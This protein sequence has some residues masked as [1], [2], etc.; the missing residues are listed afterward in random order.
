MSIGEQERRFLEPEVKRI[1]QKQ[2][3]FIRENFPTASWK[4]LVRSICEAYDRIIQ[5]CFS[6]FGAGFTDQ[7]CLIALGSYG[8]KE[9]CP[10]SD[11]DLLILHNGLSRH[12]LEKFSSQLLSLL[13][14]QK[15]PV[16]HSIHTPEQ[17]LELAERNHTALT[18][19]LDARYLAGNQ[20]LFQDLI[21]KFDRI[22]KVQAQN[23]FQDKLKEQKERR[24][25]YGEVLWV[26][27]FHLLEGAGGLRDWHL[28]R[29]LSK[30]LERKSPLEILSSENLL[31]QQEKK[32]VSKA[33]E[34][35]FKTRIALHLLTGEKTDQLRIEYQ[36]DLVRLLQIKPN[37]NYLDPKDA[38]FSW[39]YSGAELIQQIL[40]RLIYWLEKK[41][42]PK[43]SVPIPQLAGVK[44]ID[45]QIEISPG[46]QKGF[47][48]KKLSFLLD[49]CVQAQL[50]L[51]PQAQAFFSQLEKKKKQKLAD[52]LEKLFSPHK[53]AGKLLA[54][55]KPTGLLKKFFPPLERAF[56][57]G[58][59]DGY[60]YFTVGWHSLRCLEILESYQQEPEFALEPDIN[61]KVLK[62][63]GLVHDL[64][65]SSNQDHSQKG[66]KISRQLAKKLKISQEESNLLA[67]LVREHLLLNHFAQRRDFYEPES[68]EYLVKKIK[69]PSRLKMLYLL[70]TADIKAVSETSWT[71]WKQEL[72]R[73]LYHLLLSTMEEKESISQQ[74]KMQ[75][76]KLEQELKEQGISRSKI[77]ELKKLPTRYLLGTP[78]EKIIHHLKLL[79]KRKSPEAI[80]IPTL[81]KSPQL[82][83]VVICDDHPGLFAQ[84]C[85]ALTAFNYNILSAEIN[86]FKDN[87]VLDI[88]ILEDI[89]A[90][91]SPNW[92]LEARSRGQK[93]IE[94]LHSLLKG[95]INLEELLKK[96]RGVFRPKPRQE[97][98]PKVLVDDK[99]SEHYVILEI[100]SPDRMGLLYEINQIIYQQGLDIHFAKISTRAEKV[101][102]I[103][104]LR[105][106]KTKAK[107]SQ[108]KISQLVRALRSRLENI[109][110]PN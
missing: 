24:K 48:E 7:L 20:R 12:R 68:I 89:I 83:L 52:K 66:A 21:Q 39:L 16:G 17:Y 46:A 69:T 98:N 75:L 100:E 30:A 62:L 40:E 32:K 105:E 76:K 106:P 88:F 63:A 15:I 50:G 70:T 45:S 97:I 44:K 110:Q 53:Y 95:E 25:K 74:V 77:E 49:Y 61:W 82:E 9:A 85:G 55:L 47:S 1:L 18:A 2:K 29:W 27:E 37:R 96:K 104:Y 81:L 33:L 103:F 91:R 64:G 99:Y 4:V 14:D 90:Q 80:I 35:L 102:D 67:F 56:Y 28:A 22:L 54:E 8:R 23:Y 34:A 36:N 6:A 3:E 26:N 58:Q 71:S 109:A 108:E 101:F 11:L 59:R 31:A 72:L 41:Y 60:H 43:P 10:H 38:L 86:T 65:K 78:Q 87:T 13:W 92:E 84:I 42:L 51:T 94:A 5:L 79:E 57:L 93:L 19:L 107:P 73:K